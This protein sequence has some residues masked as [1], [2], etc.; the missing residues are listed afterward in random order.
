MFT[1]LLQGVALGFAAAIQPGPF[2]AYLLSQSMKNGWKHTLPA[3]LAPLI[4]D[5][6]VIILMVLILTQLPVWFQQSLQIAGGLFLLYLAVGAFRDFLQ[7]K[8]I[9]IDVESAG[10]SVIKAGIMNLLNPNP[11]IFWASVAGPL[12]VAGWRASPVYGMSFLAGFYTL[13]IGSLAVFIILFGMV[14][15]IGAGVTKTLSG[16]AALALLLFGGYLILSGA[17]I[18]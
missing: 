5:S 11:Y 9:E 4:S 17:K 8:E 2:Q 15:R 1:Y 6:P 13:L 3:A 18:L 16:I 14:G 12:L 10:Q 7:P